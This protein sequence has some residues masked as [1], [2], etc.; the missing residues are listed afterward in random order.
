[1]HS[2]FYKTTCDCLDSSNF[3]NFL[4]TITFD[5][6]KQFPGLEMTDI[7]F[8]LRTPKTIVS[9]DLEKN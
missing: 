5:F 8:P 2:P 6:L 7:H 4:N 9:E 3:L 1:M